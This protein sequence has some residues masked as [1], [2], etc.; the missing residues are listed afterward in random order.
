[1]NNPIQN[2]Y[3]FVLLFDVQDGNPNGDPDAGNLPRID[4]ETGH[5]LV[6]VHGGLG[7]GAGGGCGVFHVGGYDTGRFIHTRNPPQH[8]YS[9]GR[10][11]DRPGQ[12][13]TGSA[14]PQLA[15]P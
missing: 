9:P 13:G 1:M 7:R 11:T 10:W 8:P 6:G 3:D 2:R 5:G 4:P 14:G 12:P 15:P